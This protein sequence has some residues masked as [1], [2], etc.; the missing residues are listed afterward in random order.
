MVFSSILFLFLF[1][2]V[3]LLF[4]YLS[5]K[6][7]RNYVA[8]L[9][10]YIFYAWGA[11]LFAL[12]LLISS[13]IDFFLGKFIY[14]HKLH[15]KK[16]RLCLI[17]S[18][19]INVGLLVYFKYANFFVAE[20]SSLLETLGFR[21]VYWTK[22][23]LPIGISFFTF[24]KMSYIIDVYRHKVKPAKKFTDFALYVALFPQLIAG[25]IVRYHDVAKQLTERKYSLYKFYDGIFRFCLG[26]GKKVLI[27]N[28]V[29]RIA[30]LIFQT[31]VLNLQMSYVW[32]GVLAYAMQI[33]F[34]FS[35]YSD[36][37]IGLGKM[38]GFTFLENFNKPYIA[39]NISEFWQRWHIS[40]S[41]WMKE[42]LYIPLGGNR[43]SDLRV[44]FNLWLVF[45]ISG[46]WH[47]AAWNFIVWGAFHGLFITLDKVFWLKFS[48]KIP[49]AINISIN[50][51]I[52]LISWVFFRSNTLHQAW[53]YLAKM[54]NIFDI[55]NAFS[56]LTW[57]D[58]FSHRNLIVL[59]IALLISFVPAFNLFKKQLHYWQRNIKNSNLI[60]LKFICI[61]SLFLLSVISLINSSFNPFI[62]F[63]F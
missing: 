61:I 46:L 15:K 28:E 14:K 12:I 58:I 62:Y 4:Y 44:Y 35:G 11:P 7:Y 38:M 8:L 57:G 31:D 33:Y 27:A 23:V 16:A 45:I 52:V 55:S 50:F 18:L 6:K 42:Y 43:V 26:L 5:P 32:V 60:I 39:K 2:P 36:M 20:F 49:I 51:L 29:G 10:S 59:V 47:G 21:A 13:A 41:N 25:P 17:I 54:F 22:I 37:A 24:Q 19:V 56:Y 3:F 9:A 1:L 63:R 34:D 40:L 48:K 53:A 30:D